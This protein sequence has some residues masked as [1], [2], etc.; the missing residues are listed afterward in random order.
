MKRAVVL[1]V[2][3]ENNEFLIETRLPGQKFEGFKMA[4]GGHVV[5]GEEPLQ[6][7]HRECY[8]ELGLTNCIFEPRCELVGFNGAYVYV[9]E[10]MSYEGEIPKAVLDTNSP[11][12]WFSAEYIKEEFNPTVAKALGL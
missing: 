12:E 10:L 6:A 1:V 8:E 3:N 4:P 7:A 9:Y 5:D 2:K 11:L